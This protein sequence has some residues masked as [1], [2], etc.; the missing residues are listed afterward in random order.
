MWKSHFSNNPLIFKSSCYCFLQISLVN[1][2]GPRLVEKKRLT[3]ALQR[4]KKEAE[5]KKHSSASS[6]ISCG[7]E[8]V[9]LGGGCSA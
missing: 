2:R 3:A 9:R 4:E 8:I 6:L 7:S 5:W 1:T